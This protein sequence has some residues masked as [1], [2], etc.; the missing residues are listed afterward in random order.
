MPSRGEGCW[1]DK[2]GPTMKILLLSDIHANFEALSAIAEEYDA[3]LCLGD[4]VDYG[5]SPKECIAVLRDRATAIVRGNHDHAVAY[6]ADCQCHG[7]YKALSVAT[8][9]LMWE[10]L[11]SSEI[12]FLKKLPL[13]HTID[14]AGARFFLCHAAPTDPLFRYMP[15]DASDDQWK[16]ELEQVDADFVLVGH[17]HQP[18]KRRIGHQWVINP[19]SVGQ[20]KSASSLASYAVWQDGTLVHKEISYDYRLTMR[21]IDQTGLGTHIKQALKHVLAFGTLA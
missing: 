13:V 1:K 17:T 3:L 18:F 9:Q 6:R 15:P 10:L 21:K 11:D 19:G 16:T 4:L 14:L 12:E 7:D 20:S 8:R 5:P 2:L